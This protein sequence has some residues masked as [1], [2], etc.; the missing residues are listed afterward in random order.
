MNRTLIITV[1]AALLAATPAVAQDDLRRVLE[2]VERNNLTL[3]AEA[4]ATA[5]RTFEARTGNSLEPLSVSYSS[6]GDSPQ[7]LGKEGELEVSQSFDLPMLY[8]TRSR[9]AR[10]LAQQYETEYLALRQQI[11]LEAKEVYLELCA[12]HGIMEL[13][14]PRLAAAEHMAA[15]FASRYETGDATAIDKNRTEVEYLLLKEE[16]SAV[17]MRMIE[18]SQRLA[19]L[20]GGEMPECGYTMPPAEEQMPLE[21]LLADWEEYAPELTALRLQEQGARYDVRLSRQQALPKVELGYKYE[22]GTGEHFNGFTA[23]LSIPILSNR[24]NVKR[25]HAME[26]AAK[27][28]TESALAQ[29]RSSVR[30]ALSKSGLH[31]AAAG[32]FRRPARCRRI[33]R[34]ARPDARSGPNQHRGLLLGSFDTFYSALETRIRTD[35]EY[36]LGLARLN[37][38]YM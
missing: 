26:Q 7:A 14:R 18:L 32:V 19:V 4:H 13:N 35:L 28:N 37:V 23:G 2:S 27:A 24:H 8:A 6:A 11:L 29:Q 20:N 10:T 16:L 36:R 12:L 1:A 9:I 34:H 38:I 21:V 22:Y 15:L 17:D 30:G 25:A 3:Q 33:Y 5:G 31:G